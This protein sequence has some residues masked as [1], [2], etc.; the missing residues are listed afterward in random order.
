MLETCADILLKCTADS[1]VVIEVT[2]ALAN[3]IVTD[4]IGVSAL[5]ITVITW[6]SQSNFVHWKRSQNKAL[7]WKP[8]ADG[9]PAGNRQM[10]PYHTGY[11]WHNELSCSDICLLCTPHSDPNM[12]CHLSRADPLLPKPLK[13]IWMTHED[14]TVGWGM[15]DI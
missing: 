5:F 13:S 15:Y 3:T 10:S 9:A 6:R 7:K 14:L 4:S 12:S 1:I 11:S 8:R 2:A